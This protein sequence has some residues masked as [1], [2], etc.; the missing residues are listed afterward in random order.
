MKAPSV[1]STGPSNV[2]SVQNRSV[3]RPLWRFASIQYDSNDR[4]SSTPAIASTSS[5]ATLRRSRKG[6]RM[7][8]SSRWGSST[9]RSPSSGIWTNSSSSTRT[10]I[11][12]SSAGHDGGRCI[13]RM[14]KSRFRHVG[15]SCLVLLVAL[16]SLTTMV[17]CGTSETSPPEARSAVA[18]EDGFVSRWG[19]AERAA[20]AKCLGIEGEEGAKCLQSV[21]LPRQERAGVRF[22]DAIE[23]LLDGGVGPKCADALEESRSSITS[24]PSFPGEAGAICRAESQGQ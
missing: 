11:R 2:L 20:M 7:A 3:L 19:Q 18:A 14:T 24:V 23:E 15:L 4:S 5:F 9:R 16:F 10:P 13:R 22:L 8:A 6:N 1:R 17:S 12:R 21:A